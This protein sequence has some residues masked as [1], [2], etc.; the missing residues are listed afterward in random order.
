MSTDLQAEERC[1]S[2]YY[3]ES[4]GK[5][6]GAAPGRA[7]AALWVR[8]AA[9]SLHSPTLFS[10][11]AGH[12][13]CRKRPAVA[14]FHVCAAASLEQDAQAFRLVEH[15]RKM[16]GRVSLWDDDDVVK[17]WQKKKQQKEGGEQKG[18]ARE[19]KD[20]G[21]AQRAARLCWGYVVWRRVSVGKGEERDQE[22]AETRG[23]R[24]PRVV[25]CSLPSSFFFS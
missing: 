22:G 4:V 19:D 24:E 13:L 8:A 1:A 18:R 15:G 2:G 5:G 16:R 21:E 12:S 6:G 14:C 7:R 10:V 17:R 3:G 9:C 20:S 25:L 11:A 23:R